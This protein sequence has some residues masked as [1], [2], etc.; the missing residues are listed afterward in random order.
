MIDQ[1]FN[2]PHELYRVRQ[3]GV[4]LERGLVLPVRM[5][6]EQLGIAGGPERMDG[7]AA[8]LGARR[9]EDAEDRLRDGAGVARPSMKSG[10]DEELHRDTM[11]AV[12][13]T[14]FSPSPPSR[15]VYMD[16]R[17]RRRPAAGRR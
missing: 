12:R 8:R 1:R 7:E 9:S 3:R 11:I 16:A 4:Q 6:V 5:D 15:D 2:S 14:T 13:R 17:L 10:E